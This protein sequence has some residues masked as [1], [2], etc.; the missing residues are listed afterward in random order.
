MP[1]YVLYTKPR[2]EKKIAALLSEQDFF[3][4]CPVKEEIR[5]WSDRK[6][7]VT[8]PV[9]KSYV[10]V[11][12]ND[13]K[14][15]SPKI[16]QIPG[17]LHFLWWN[18]Q[19]GIVREHEIESIRHFL[20]SYKHAKIDTA[21]SPGESVIITEGILADKNGVVLHTQGNVVYLQL[22]S[23][24]LNMIARIPAQSLKKNT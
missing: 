2:N 9:F 16:L 11:F 17:A 20:T 4:Y 7:K 18:K 10:F 13:Y 5:Q 23:I 24:G 12:L 3:V 8:E 21:L 19:P 14:A 22:K 15:E 1:W 6:K